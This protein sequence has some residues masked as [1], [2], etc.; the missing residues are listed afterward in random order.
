M[1]SKTGRE[2]GAAPVVRARLV[3]YGLLTLLFG[4]VATGSELWPLSQFE[5]FSSVRTGT[6]QSWQLVTVDQDGDETLVDLGGLP[7]NLGLVHHL[8]PGLPNQPPADQ[9]ATVR[10]WLEAVG[11][12]DPEPA[13][14][15]IY[16]VRRTVPVAA[17]AA[18]TE[19]GRTLAAEIPLR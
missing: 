7:A 10:L 15:R 16:T 3:T 14:A 4:T 19:L 9:Q 2:P 12:D 17:G 18:P 11:A 8:L 6:G 13:A 5:L 1:R